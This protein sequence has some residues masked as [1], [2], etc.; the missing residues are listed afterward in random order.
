MGC[1]LN[2]TVYEPE[3]VARKF[4]TNISVHTIIFMCVAGA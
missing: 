1:S 3:D 4:G 2:L